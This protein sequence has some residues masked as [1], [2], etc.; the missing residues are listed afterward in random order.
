MGMVPLIDLVPEGHTDAQCRAALRSS[1]RFKP[2]GGRWL[3]PP[4]VA[5]QV[6]NYLQRSV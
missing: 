6:R 1:R 4:R 2:H 3:F 5:N